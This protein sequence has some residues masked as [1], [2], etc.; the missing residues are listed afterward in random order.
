[1]L[2]LEDS[3]QH[4]KK[5]FATFVNK[6]RKEINNN[7]IT[8]QLIMSVLNKKSQENWNA[9]TILN[10]DGKAVA[11]VMWMLKYSQ[12]FTCSTGQKPTSCISLGLQYSNLKSRHIFLLGRQKGV[13]Q[14]EYHSYLGSNVG[15]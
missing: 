2:E 13:Y 15:I 8:T 9:H 6:S 5:T 1:M 3:K 10:L 11:N 12:Q 4:E 7:A 14:I